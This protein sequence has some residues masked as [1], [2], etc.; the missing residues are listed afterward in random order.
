[1]N[2]KSESDDEPP[3]LELREKSPDG[4]SE[5]GA[6][7]GPPTLDAELPTQSHTGASSV[8]SACFQDLQKS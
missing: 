2:T 3:K 4:S 8:L 6:Q 1:M 7:S 5:S